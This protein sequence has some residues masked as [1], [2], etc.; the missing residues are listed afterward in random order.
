[1]G[2]RTSDDFETLL[3]VVLSVFSSGVS[4]GVDS[5]SSRR[6]VMMIASSAPTRDVGGSTSVE[7]CSSSSTMLSSASLKSWT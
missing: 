2:K 1:M 6:G 4:L 7:P 3:R 5:D